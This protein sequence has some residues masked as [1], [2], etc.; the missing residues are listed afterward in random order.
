MHSSRAS[1]PS[2]IR[3]RH[4]RNEL[5]RS[6]SL[7]ILCVGAST[8]V[9]ACAGEDP[10]LETTNSVEVA[11]TTG[12]TTTATSTSVETTDATATTSSANPSGV[13]TAPD[14]Q[15]KPGVPLPPD[16][17]V[18]LTEESRTTVVDG[19]T[20]HYLVS[21][22]ADTAN[23]PLPVIF[24]LHGDNSSGGAIRK[25]LPLEAHATEAAVFVYP[26]ATNGT[27]EYFNDEGRAHEAK[28]VN[29]ALSELEVT[30]DIDR[31]RV[32]LVGFSGGATMANSLACRLG[33][34]VI[35]G[36]GIHSG[37]LFSVD[38]GGGVPDFEMTFVGE[39]NCNLPATLIVWGE[40][41]R[42]SGVSFAAGQATRDLYVATQGCNDTTKAGL[43]G[44]CVEYQDCTRPVVW[45]P[46]PGLAHQAWISASEVLWDF[47]GQTAE[48]APL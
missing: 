22:P 12:T 33:A 27:F 37:T 11:A 41:D 3:K 46:I 29:A 47:V 38:S 15:T 28:F 39:T 17:L 32:F 21:Y 6:Q 45:C 5:L 26:D 19:E 9:S 42:T 1:S 48:V 34:D 25:T 40:Q 2:P 35:R 31:A 13:E 4:A 18:P 30:L 36:V 7:A 8:L 20:R 23:S 10:G 44:P 16:D 14:L 43:L 24:S